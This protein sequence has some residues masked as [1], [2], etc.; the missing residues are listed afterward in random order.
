M[1]SCR[2]RLLSPF[3]LFLTKSFRHPP[4]ILLV[5]AF[6]TLSGSAMHLLADAT[7]VCVTHM[8][9]RSPQR[10]GYDRARRCGVTDCWAA[11]LL[12][13][14]AAEMEHWPQFDR[15]SI[16]LCVRRE[17]GGGGKLLG[18]SNNRRTS[19]GAKHPIVI[20]C[21]PVPIHSCIRQSIKQKHARYHHHPKQHAHSLNPP[22]PPTRTFQHPTAKTMAALTRPSSA[23]RRG[24]ASS[25][26][27][28]YCAL[29]LLALLLCYLAP[30]ADAQVCVW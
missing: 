18:V 25:C 19:E 17:V 1:K 2:F 4:F 11:H 24:P 3:L 15:M 7:F 21:V 20:P 28:G 5:L 22:P 30:T 9:A 6:L 12:H 27:I 26:R 14:D 10:L 16:D 13:L 8:H 29:L 23:Q